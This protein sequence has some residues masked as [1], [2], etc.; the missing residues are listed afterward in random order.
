MAIV[1]IV[2]SSAI[3]LDLRHAVP[4]AEGLSRAGA[5]A[6]A[7][8][9]RLAGNGTIL[10]KSDGNLTRLVWA[11][12]TTVEAMQRERWLSMVLR[13]INVRPCQALERNPCI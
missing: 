10:P 2:K 7:W 3:S 5:N 6:T 4:A 11:Q 9:H 12:K 8:L 13:S 1:L